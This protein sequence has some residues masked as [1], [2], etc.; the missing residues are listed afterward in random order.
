METQT[1]KP[2]WE[3][4]WVWGT[5]GTSGFG[6]KKPDLEW[7]HGFGDYLDTGSKILGMEIIVPGHYVQGEEKLEEKYRVHKKHM[8][9]QGN[10]D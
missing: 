10:D 4:R 7:S 8:A 5:C 3:E 2:I 9:Y 1:K 6:I